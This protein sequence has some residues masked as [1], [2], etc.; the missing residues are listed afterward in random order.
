MRYKKNIAFILCFNR[1]YFKSYLT[2]GKGV[3]PDNMRNHVMREIPGLAE[4]G[5]SC[6]AI[7]MLLQPPHKSSTSPQIYRSFTGAKVPRKSI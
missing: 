1:V 2:T 7:P 4:R 5:I 6:D 3:S